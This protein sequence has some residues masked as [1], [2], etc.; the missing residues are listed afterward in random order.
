MSEWIS[1]KNRLPE[2]GVKVLIFDY[3]N[4]FDVWFLELD[5]TDDIVHWED[6]NGYW[7]PL[8]D[9]THWMPLPEP[10]EEVKQ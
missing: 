6:Q 4:D 8:H 5:E 2:I 7:Y 10:P 3:Y 9:A 1:M